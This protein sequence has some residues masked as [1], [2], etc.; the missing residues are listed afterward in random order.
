MSSRRPPSSRW[1][2]PASNSSNGNKNKSINSVSV[3]SGGA[4]DKNNNSTGAGGSNGGG[5]ESSTSSS[6]Q[7]QGK[8]PTVS[9]SMKVS[10]HSFS[11]M[12]HNVGKSNTHSVQPHYNYSHHHNHHN[13]HGH[14]RT[15]HNNSNYRGGRRPFYTSRG[16]GRTHNSYSYQTHSTRNMRSS[17]SSGN[18]AGNNCN[19]NKNMVKNSGPSNNFPH[20]QNHLSENRTSSA[21]PSPSSNDITNTSSA[22]DSFVATN[23]YH[24]PPPSLFSRPAQ[25]SPKHILSATTTNETKVIQS[26]AETSEAGTLSSGLSDT[27]GDISSTPQQAPPTP[28]PSHGQIPHQPP[29]HFSNTQRLDNASCHSSQICNVKIQNNPE[30]NF[31]SERGNMIKKHHSQASNI[32]F[33]KNQ[34]NAQQQ[35]RENLSSSLQEQKQEQNKY[36]KPQQQEKQKEQQKQSHSKKTILPPYNS[37][38]LRQSV[39]IPLSSQMSSPPSYNQSTSNSFAIS[40]NLKRKNP[41]ANSER[42]ETFC[43]NPI[44]ESYR[45]VHSNVAT[46]TS[47]TSTPALSPKR[48]SHS[49]FTNK[50][51]V[52]EYHNVP[53]HSRD[54]NK[55]NHNHVID[56]GFKA[57]MMNSK[58][59]SSNISSNYLMQSNQS[60]G[61]NDGSKN[62]LNSVLCDAIT[63]SL[64]TLSN[65]EIS[66]FVASSK[67]KPF[68]TPSESIETQNKSNDTTLTH[69]ASKVCLFKNC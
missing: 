49:T 8:G 2:P 21:I 1:G 38:T 32:Q 19:G 6:I 16:G 11:H 43:S 57:A 54:G 67:A 50:G 42:S 24:S 53:S 60:F 17:Y 26:T 55:T 13:N 30:D 69:F 66:T 52:K 65:D 33:I 22:S 31:T 28:Q 45:Y 18:S 14:Y 20:I 40:T 27:Q 41:N 36:Y 58:K 23:K 51:Y 64:S 10:N 25:W 35:D 9:Q 39:S 68:S 15:Y 29:R 12:N 48:H 61:Y 44:D 59:K 3:S 5:F 34:S 56:H 4:A 62:G 37:F 7:A 46:S 47:S 63:P